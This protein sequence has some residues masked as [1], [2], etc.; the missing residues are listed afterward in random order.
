M[1]SLNRKDTI[2]IPS[3]KELPESWSMEREILE[4]QG[5]QSLIVVPILNDSQLI[6]FVGLDS[7]NQLKVYS[8]SEINM[9]KVWSNMLASI[10][11][12]QRVEKLLN[13]TRENYE[14]FFNTID[15]FLFVLDVQGKIIHTNKTVNNRLGYSSED[16]LDKSVLMV[17][18][19]EQREE[20]GRIVGEMLAGT[21]EFCPVPLE[22]KSG[23]SI[24]VETKVKQG[25]WNGQPVIFGV[26]KDISKIKLSEEKFSKAFHSNSALMA[27]SG[28]DN[29]IF[30]DVNNSFV[31]KVGFSRDELIGKYFADFN[32]I[33]GLDFR[34]KIKDKL[35]QNILVRDIEINLRPR[36]GEVI[37][38][39]LSVDSIYIE[40]Q[41]CLLIL[42]VDITDRKRTE[43][44]LRKARIEADN[45]NRAKSEFLSRM[46]H[47]LRTPLNSILG[48][49]QLMEMSE[50]IPSHKKR[51]N[52]ILNN[53]KHLLNLINEVLDIAGIES[54][55]QTL[56]IAN[57]LL[58]GII[59]EVM[60]VVQV[61][62]NKRNVNICHDFV[63]VLVGF[64]KG[65]I[66]PLRVL[67]HFQS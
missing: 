29:G 41:K 39:M 10:L 49:A 16:L 1:E 5:V 22:T 23:N 48:F 6:G 57:V 30:I 21:S 64:G 32:I 26:S 2:I 34:E 12:K 25:Y 13:Q 19:M 59:N 43:E 44:N 14:I 56:T 8:F 24:A 11:N 47:E 15:D 53:G 52:H 38:G 54:G 27:I 67:S 42:I 60:D 18:P 7:V 35:N 9:L 31:E 65:P 50:L 51:V 61:V 55:K 37:I 33:E 4:P 40:N 46:S 58:K 36:S 45:A 3:V 17:H 66:H 20:A 63:E 62:A 28:F